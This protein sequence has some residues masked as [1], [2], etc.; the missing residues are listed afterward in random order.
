MIYRSTTKKKLLLI[1]LS[2]FFVSFVSATT[3]Y[4]IAT[5]NG[6]AY[7]IMKVVLDGKSAFVVSVVENAKSAQSL[8]SLMNA[9]S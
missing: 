7:K 3:T 1:V 5:E 4:S 2:I 9:V 8:K 6:H